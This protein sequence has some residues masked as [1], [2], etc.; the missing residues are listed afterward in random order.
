MFILNCVKLYSYFGK[1][2]DFLG[3]MLILW[4]VY[5][6]SRTE[7]HLGNIGFLIVIVINLICGFSTFLICYS[8]MLN[9]AFSEGIYEPDSMRKATCF[10][11]SLRIFFLSCF[12]PLFPVLITAF[13]FIE[14]STYILLL[15]CGNKGFEVVERSFTLLYKNLFGLSRR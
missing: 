3:D 8:S 9:I 4:V 6:Q 11:K 14:Y 5:N 1:L 7:D 12:G 10:E 15:L 2:A 13:S